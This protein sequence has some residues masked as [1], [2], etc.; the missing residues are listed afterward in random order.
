MALWPDGTLEAHLVSVRYN[1]YETAGMAHTGRPF[2][3]AKAYLEVQYKGAPA[4]VPLA[5]SGV[6]ILQLTP[7]PEPEGLGQ[8]RGLYEQS[9]ARKR[10]GG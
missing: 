8:A 1:D 2:A 5:G 4:L 7:A 10:K 6:K 9:Q 3:V